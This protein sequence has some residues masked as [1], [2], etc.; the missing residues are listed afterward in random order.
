MMAIMGPGTPGFNA[1][2]LGGSMLAIEG[3]FNSRGARHRDAGGQRD[4][5]G[6]ESGAHVRRDTSVRSMAS[7]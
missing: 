1:L 2:M 5:H 4:H 7:A 6:S 3:G